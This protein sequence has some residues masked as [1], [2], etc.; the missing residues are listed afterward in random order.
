MVLLGSY[1]G[2]TWVVLWCY[3][4]GIAME[5][6]RVEGSSWKVLAAE[7]KRPLSRPTRIIISLIII[8]QW[9]ELHFRCQ[10]CF[11]QNLHLHLPEQRLN[12]KKCLRFTH[13]SRDC[14]SNISRELYWGPKCTST[15]NRC[16]TII[17][18]LQSSN[19]CTQA[20]LGLLVTSIR[21]VR[22]PKLTQQES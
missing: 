20:L 9:L 2:I 1:C 8:H 4:G 18:I 11:Q 12:C 14:K 16:T 5:W 17:V 10:A 19:D 13:Y 6:V 22:L 15:R 7:T 3:L 21:V